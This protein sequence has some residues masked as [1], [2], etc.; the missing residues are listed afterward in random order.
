VPPLAVGTEARSAALFTKISIGLPPSTFRA[1]AKNRSTFCGPSQMSNTNSWTIVSGIS[2]RIR[3]FVSW[4][5]DAVRPERKTI[6][7]PALAKASAGAALMPVPDPVMKIDFPQMDIN[8]TFS[9]S[10]GCV[11][12][13]C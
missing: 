2:L 13:E 5:V 9:W 8:F 12:V 7:V 10:S 3:F 6:L 1:T 11:V 4:S